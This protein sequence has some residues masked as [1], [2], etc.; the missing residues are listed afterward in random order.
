MQSFVQERRGI[1]E[2]EDLVPVPDPKDIHELGQRP[3]APRRPLGQA[4]LLAGSTEALQQLVHVA[5]PP[6]EPGTDRVW[7]GR[8]GRP[9]LGAFDEEAGEVHT[10]IHSELQP[11]TLA[12]PLALAEG[13]AFLMCSDGW[14]DHFEVPA[15]EASLAAANGPESWLDDMRRHIE[16]AA[17]PRQDNYSAIAIWVGDLTQ[18][19][20]LHSA[21]QLP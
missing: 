1:V 9:A 12:H 3:Q 21:Y 11:H 4:Q 5:P 2:P 16:Q 10:G 19:T 6:A 13:D 20:L 18:I 8:R 17:A 7:R 15:L 14:W